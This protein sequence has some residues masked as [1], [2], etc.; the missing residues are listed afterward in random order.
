M[1]WG[2]RITILYLGFVSLIITM[3]S[4]TMR[5]KVDLVA[6]DY[7]AQELKYQDRIDEINR[8]KKLPEQLTWEI[9]PGAIFYQFPKHL[10]NANIKA[11][12]HFFRPSDANLD[13]KTNIEVDTS[14][15]YLLSTEKIPAGV[16]KMQISWEAENTNYYNEGII[17]LN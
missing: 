15:V 1:S 6:K 8:T 11:R 12:I 5:E 2:I 14:G 7:Y 13:K 4:L 10:K 3:V 9:K 17:R 16:Y